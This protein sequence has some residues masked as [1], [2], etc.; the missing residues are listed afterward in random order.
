MA[1]DVGS[2]IRRAREQAGLSQH[3]LATALG[4]SSAATISHFENGE[5]TLSVRDLLRIAGTL[6]V[7]AA[8]L[9]GGEQGSSPSFALRASQIVPSARDAVSA[10]LSFATSRGGDP[11]KLSPDLRKKKPRDVVAY[12]LLR[13][14]INKPPVDPILIAKTFGIPVIEWD[15]DDQISGIFVA[16]DKV[17]IGVNKSH[18][19]TRRRFTT[20]H[21]IGHLIYGIGAEEIVFDFLGRERGFAFDS[22]ADPEIEIQ[23]NHLAA[24]LLMPSRWMYKEA[25][26]EGPDVRALA[27]RYGVSEQAM[28]FR[29]LNLKL[30]KDEAR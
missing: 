11:P 5:R 13:A 30:V 6:N 22:T 17:A 29:L 15:F 7:P 25:D 28:W 10:F 3:D 19:R 27:R 24:E 21:E 14:K 9:L 12:L 2:R 1:D 26:I 16:G 4:Y 8:S 20:A 23:A 18:P